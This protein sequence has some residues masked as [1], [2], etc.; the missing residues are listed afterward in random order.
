MKKVLKIIGKILLVIVGLLLIVAAYI[1]FSGIPSYEVNAPDL[2]IEYDSTRIAR[3]AHLASM[4]CANCHRGKS[5]LLDGKQMLDAPPEFGKI[6][7]PNITH[8]PDSKLSPYTD[9]ELAYLLRTGIKRDGNFAPP[10]MQ[11][12]P[13]M[14]DED[15]YSVIAWLRSDD[16]MLAPSDVQQPA[17]E[18]SFLSKMLCRVA[19]KPLP[20]PDK[21]IEA[22][23]ITDKV[24][25]G[26]YLTTAA[27]ECY[28]CHSADFKTMD[29]LVPENTVGYFGGGNPLLDE[30]G[31]VIPSANL[32]PHATGLADWTYEEFSRTL[33]TGLRPDGTGVSTAMPKF[34]QFSDQEIE[35]IWAYLQTL[36]P[37]D[38]EVKR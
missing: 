16:P 31:N 10:W 27:V 6:W 34:P 11:K 5:G 19:F 32:T 22:P 24:A 20:Y 30:E 36:P 21:P 18:P 38:N 8:H 33:R 17:C 13:L 9:G 28:A 1:N 29:M 15:L 12:F 35:A 3:G 26:R 4:I 2:K 25:Y 7:A 14:S 37:I 23:P